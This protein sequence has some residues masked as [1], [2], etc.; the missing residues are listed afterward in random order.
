MTLRA[1]SL[2]VLAA[3]LLPL[4][5]HALP[6][7]DKLAERKARAERMPSHDRGKIYS[8]IA[9]D[10]AALA[11]DR[12]REG[13]EEMALATVQESL[14]FAKK[15]G[16]AAAERG[17]KIKD[18]EINLRACSR[19]LGDLARTLSLVD[20]EPVQAAAAE[21]DQVRDHLLSLM[22]SPKKKK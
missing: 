5:A 17:K 13:E 16:D 14:D 2:Y 8:E 4:P 9:L 11:A 15:A 19:R 3:F 1:I 21:I 20:R 6:V 12:F 10:L 18:T 22:F 7:Q